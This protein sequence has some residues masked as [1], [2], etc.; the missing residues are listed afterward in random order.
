MN[1]TYTLTGTDAHSCS[2]TDTV[3]VNMNP[4]TT[5]SLCYVTVD[6]LSQYIRCIWEKPLSNAIDS[7][8]VYR[9]GTSGY[10]LRKALPYSAF[11]SWLDSTSTPNSSYVRY[12]I[13]LVDTCGI[14]S[15]LSNYHSSMFLQANLG[16]GGVINLNWAPYEGTAVLYYRIMRDDDGTGNFV[17]LDSVPASNLLYTDANPPASNNAKYAVEVVWPATC[18]PSHKT[19]AASFN[20]SRSN[21][22]DKAAIIANSIGDDNSFVKIYPNPN[23]GEF[24]IENFSSSATHY[25]IE[26]FDILGNMVY[27]KEMSGLKKMKLDI[28]GRSQ[29]IYFVKV[30][31]GEKQGVVKK[32]IIQ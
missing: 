24:V 19:E 11:T 16:V 20:T 7:F 15:P 9:E 3:T 17:K 23:N 18:G 1:I 28:S 30:L 26:I 25:Q 14:E 29:G 2:S 27:N 5:L 12:K 4:I 22:K 32:I 6:S 8:R 31:S 13:S 21:L 10:K